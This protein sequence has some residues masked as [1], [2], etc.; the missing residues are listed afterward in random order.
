MYVSTDIE[1]LHYKHENIHYKVPTFGRIYKII[2]FGRAIYRF[3]NNQFCSD[4]FARNGDGWTQYNC[5]PFFDKYKEKIV[6]NYSFDLTRLACSIIEIIIDDDY[7]TNTEFDA[8]LSDWLCDDNG[9]SVLFK[10][11]KVRYPGF[12]LYKMI[13]KTVHKH[14]PSAQLVRPCFTKY[15]YIP[16]KDHGDKIMNINKIP[17]YV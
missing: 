7:L 15:A 16:L 4:S 3:S 1:F 2:D 13:A 10:E 11:K 14:I 17:S 12:K 8:I 9:I 6:P 5:P